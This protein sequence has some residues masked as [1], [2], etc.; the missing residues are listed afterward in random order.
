[1]LIDLNVTKTSRAK[2]GNLNSPR[3][4]YNEEQPWFVGTRSMTGAWKSKEADRSSGGRSVATRES[5]ILAGDWEDADQ[6]PPG[7]IKW[8]GNDMINFA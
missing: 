4:D 3:L 2:D 5:T 6:S 7:E 8:K 1:M